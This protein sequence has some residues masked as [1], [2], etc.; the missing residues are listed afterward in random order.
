MRR[1]QHGKHILS[2]EDAPTLFCFPSSRLSSILVMAA[3]YSPLFRSEVDS[4]TSH[5][6]LSNAGG[7]ESRAPQLE[8]GVGHVFGPQ[9]AGSG[10]RVLW[11]ILASHID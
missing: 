7:S 4:N 6:G 10:L 2:E 1:V 11:I 5:Q 8:F 3:A 9:L